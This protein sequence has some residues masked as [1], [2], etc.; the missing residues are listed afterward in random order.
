MD[1]GNK[2]YIYR[3]DREVLY[4]RDIYRGNIISPPHFRISLINNNSFMVFIF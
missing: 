3:G 2:G 4:I 1:G